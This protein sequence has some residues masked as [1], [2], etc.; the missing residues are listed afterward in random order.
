PDGMASSLG[1][2]PFTDGEVCPGD[3]LADMDPDDQHFEEAT[4]NEGASFERSYQRAALVLWPQA[5]RLALAARAGFAVSLPMLGSLVA[6]WVDEG[7]QAG[8]TTWREAHALAAQMLAC[9]P[10]RATG[11]GSEGRGAEA[12]M[13]AHLTRLQD[14]EHIDAMLAGV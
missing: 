13:L 2:M 9:W 7:A 14:L 10:V 3:A 11:H 1:T 8:S 12:T 6:A 4:G 5:Q